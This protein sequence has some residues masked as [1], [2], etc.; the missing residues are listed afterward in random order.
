MLF[1]SD[2][3]NPIH[4]QQWHNESVM[5]LKAQSGKHINEELYIS[6]PSCVCIVQGMHLFPVLKTIKQQSSKLV[7]S[8]YKNENPQLEQIACRKWGFGGR[9]Q[10]TL[11][12]VVAGPQKICSFDHLI[13][14]S[15]EGGFNAKYRSTA[16]QNALV[17]GVGSKPYM[18]FHYAKEGLA[19]PVLADVARVVASKIKSALPTWFGGQKQSSTEPEVQITPPELMI[20]RFGLCDQQRN[21]SNIWLAP[22]NKLAVVADNLGRIVL[23]DCIKGIALRLWKGYRDA[24]CGFIEV[25]EK[26]QKTTNSAEKRR[27][28]FLIIYAPKRKVIEIW[29]LQNGPKIAAFTAS[30]NGHLIYN[31]HNLMGVT[32][33]SSKIKYS[34]AHTCI[35]F[36]PDDKN[37]EIKEFSIPF[38][39]A[40][41]D[42]NSTTAKDLHLLKRLKIFLKSCDGNEEQDCKEM[43]ETCQSFGTNEIKLQCLE[44][45]VKNKKIKPK[46]LQSALLVF[47]EDEEDNTDTTT[48]LQIICKNY[49]QITKLFIFANTI[50]ECHEKQ[51]EEDQEN[52]KL[53]E[54][55]LNTIQKLLSINKKSSSTSSVGNK[56][57]FI[58]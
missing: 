26:V 29:S 1:Y 4:S 15:L 17:I 42:S 34:T 36:D 19:Q 37:S 22:G 11:D 25:S 12:N 44:M 52:M 48:H 2:N 7:F 9:G 21:A 41:S 6:Y 47:S 38:H 3:G 8:V 43:T 51:E 23:V 10:T 50:N 54:N 58:N 16:P 57:S 18:G 46:L 13:T 32:H 30:G 5:S 40:L 14:A 27:A 55:E 39:C 53:S 35:F 45:L 20:C 56:V 31:T 28:M 24:Q 33:S 49:L